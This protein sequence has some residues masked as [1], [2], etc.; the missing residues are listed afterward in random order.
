MYIY[1]YA[2]IYIC[3]C[4]YIYIHLFLHAR[5]LSLSLSVR[6]AD[7]RVEQPRMR[8][9]KLQCWVDFGSVDIQTGLV[10]PM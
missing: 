6:S 2:C 3:K 4:V 8:M 5:S 7:D 9:P 10:S 1:I